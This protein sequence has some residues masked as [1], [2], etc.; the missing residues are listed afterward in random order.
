VVSVTI[1]RSQ[2]THDRHYSTDPLPGSVDIAHKFTPTAAHHLRTVM[3]PWSRDDVG[4]VGLDGKGR[5]L[6]D[7]ATVGSDAIGLGAAAVDGGAEA[8][9]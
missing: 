1:T 8:S 4:T 6:P 5:Q 9:A 2:K 7:T 3:Y